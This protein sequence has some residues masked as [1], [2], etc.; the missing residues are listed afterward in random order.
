MT[1]KD[2]SLLQFFVSMALKLACLH[3]AGR[4]R[5]K[6]SIQAEDFDST[7]SGFASAYHVNSMDHGGAISMLA[8][9]IP[10]AVS[11]QHMV[12]ANNTGNGGN[13]TAADPIAGC[14]TGSNLDKQTVDRVSN[15]E[16]GTGGGAVDAL[17][18]PVET[19]LSQPTID[20]ASHSHWR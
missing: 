4:S 5:L 20:T 8:S 10:S 18:A 9:P 17:G 1:D 7:I 14:S 12:A 16:R 13:T 3:D 15:P 6:T 19:S 11:W 2:R